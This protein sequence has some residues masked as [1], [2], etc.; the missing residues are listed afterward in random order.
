MSFAY[1][2]TFYP[3][4]PVLPVVLRV[5]EGQSSDKLPALIDTGADVTFVPAT[6]LRRLRAQDSHAARV[7]SHWGEWRVVTIFVIDIEVAG[8]TLPAVDV[9]ADEQG[10]MILL[11]RSVLNRLLLLLDGPGRQTDV[12]TRRPVR[13]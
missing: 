9:I 8:E 5:F 1:N 13:F 7:R 6:L 2:P 10:D 3:P 12:L 11:G 4:F